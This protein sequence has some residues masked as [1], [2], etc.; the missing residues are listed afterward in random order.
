VSTT[1]DR[2]RAAMRA[3]AGTVDDAPPLRL[4]AAQDQDIAPPHDEAAPDE[5]APDEAARDEAARDE[6]VHDEVRPGERG[7]RRLI[8]GRPGPRR[9]DQPRPGGAPRPAGPSRDRRRRW[10]LLAPVAAAVTIVAVAV[11][12]VI[13]RN[14]P[15]GSVATPPTPASSASGAGVPAN[16]AVV[17]EYYVA[18]MQADT[19]Y[20]VVGD[21][22]TGQAIATVKAPPGVFFTEVYGAA[23]DDRTFVVTGDRSLGGADAGTVW[24]LLRIAPGSGTPARLS[25][26]PVPVRQGPAGVALSPDGTEVAVALPGSPAALRVYAVAT[27][28]LLR[29]WSTA[30][31]GVFMPD[32]APAEGSW[33]FTAQ[34]VRWSPDGRQLAFTWNASDVWVLDAAAPDGDLIAS[35]RPLAGIGTGYDSLGSLTCNAWQGW[36][37]ITVTKGAAAGQ[38]I[39]CAGSAQ[40]GQYTPCSSP[41]STKCKYAQRNSVGFL[42][43]TKDSQGGSYQGLDSGYACPSVSQPEN[44]AYLGWA[45]ADGSEVIGS[46]VCGGHARFGIFRGG[47]FTPLPAL[48]VSMP[49]PAGMMAGTVAW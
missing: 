42:R 3:I 44:G 34:V 2:A 39:V 32:R 15:N 7:T 19:P 46:Q 21:T 35:S 13:I 11:A 45:N 37:P 28:A 30:T 8:P 27:G 41:T 29:A 47:K 1:E 10:S 31:R 4:A 23:A 22:F 36:Q 26:L 9:S 16:A 20:L 48:P 38:G 43:A 25:A 49:L 33:K 18:W 12:L 24:Y 14:I 6:A 17:P 5:A 40:S